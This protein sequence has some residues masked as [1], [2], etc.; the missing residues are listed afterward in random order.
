MKD[1]VGAR[2][3]D[4]VYDL[5]RFNEVCLDLGC[6]LGHIAPHLIKENVGTLLQCDMSEKMVERSRGAPLGE[7]H[8]NRVI[9]DEELIPFRAA[10]ADLIL[11]SLAAHWIN[12][13]AAW[14]RRCL[15][16][17]RPDGCMIGAL[18]SGVTLYQLRV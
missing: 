15:N 7:F 17:L 11:S 14:F 16:V 12:D 13:L 3:A 2:V 1:E 10:S 5:V 9:A 6:G 4:R 18:F 8:T